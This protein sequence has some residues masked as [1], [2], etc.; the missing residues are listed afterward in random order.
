MPVI[1]LER[2]PITD[3]AQF[4]AERPDWAEQVREIV[5]FAEQAHVSRE[6]IPLERIVIRKKMISEEQILRD[7]VR[8]Q[9][10]TRRPRP[11][12]RWATPTG[13]SRRG[14]TV[15]DRS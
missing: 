15:R 10:R 4:T 14:P 5:L 9:R 12:P 11:G 6:V 1:G 13:V 8:T 2:V 3:P 7:S